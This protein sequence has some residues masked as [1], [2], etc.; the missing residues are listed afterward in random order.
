MRSLRSA[1][2]GM[3]RLWRWQCIVAAHVMIAGLTSAPT[4][5]LWR[6]AYLLVAIP[7]HV[8]ALFM[9]ML[10]D[11]LFFLLDHVPV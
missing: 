3:E 7:H 11:V 2:K 8:D 6:M 1:Q 5:T 4:V 10:I 9:S